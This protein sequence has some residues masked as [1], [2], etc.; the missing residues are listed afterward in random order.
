MFAKIA[1][2]EFRYQ[3][4]QPV[5]WIAA[6]ILFLFTFG[7][8]TIDQIHIGSGGN[9]HKNAPYALALTTLIMTLIYMFVTTA[10]VSNVIVRDDD[11]GFGPILRATPLSKFDY[12]NGRFV[13][14]FLVSAIGF[15][16][17]P[18]GIA[19][20]SQMPWLDPEVVGPVNLSDY[21]FAYFVLALPGV[22]LTSAI[23]FT[24][25]TVTRSMMWT[26]VGVVGFLIIYTVVSVALAQKTELR[27]LRGY[28][29]PFG[30]A[31]F[32]NATRYWTASERNTLMPAFTGAILGNRLIW[33]GVGFVALALAQA[34]FGFRS[35]G[36]K[37]RKHLK[38]LA[39]ASVEEAPPVSIGRL[40]KP[41]F[42]GVTARAQLVART[43]FEMGQVFKSPAYFVLLVLGLF[44][45]FGGLWFAREIY[46]TAVYP[47][48]RITIQT[49]QGTFTIIP[50]IIAIYYAGELVWRERDRKTHEIIDAT[51]IPNWAFVF[52][53]TLAIAL[54]LISTLAISVVGAIAVQA[55]KGYDNFEL[56]KFLLWYIAPNAI[57]MVLLAA[58]AVFMQSISPHKFVGWGLMV[59]YLISTLVLSN[60]GFDQNLYHYS[61]SPNVPLSDMNGRGQF[62]IGQ[63]WFQ[64]YWGAF[65]LFLLLLSYGLWRRGTETRLWPRLRR[66]PRAFAGPA[67]I[68]AFLSLAI[69]A[70]TGAWIYL[71]TNVWNEHRTSIDNDKRTAA[72]EKALLRFE[73]TPQPTAVSMTFALDLFPHDRKLVTHGSYVLENRTGAPLEAVHL[74]ADDDLKYLSVTLPG[75][76]LDH[77]YKAFNYRIYKFDTPLAPGARVTLSFVTERHQIGFKNGQDTTKIVDNGTFLNNADFAPMIGIDRSGFLQDRAKRRLYGLPPELRLAKLEDDSARAKNYVG[78]APWVMADITVTTDADQTPIAPGYKVS[79]TTHNGRRTAEF[80][81][82][83]PILAFFSVQ[84]AHYAEKHQLYKGIDIAVYYDKQHP[85]NVNRMI[86]AAETGLDYYQANFSPYQ[87][88]QFRFIEFPDYAQ[89]A[90]SFANT[91]PWSEGLGF[92]AD[93]RKSEDIDYVTYVGAHELG[94]QWW[95]HQEVSAEMQGGT[96]LVETLA[97]YSALMVMEKTYGPDKIRQFLKYELDNYLRSRG[98][99]VVEEVPLERVE[100]QGYIH[101]RKGAVVMYLLKDQIGEEAVNRAL[102]KL[103][104]KYAFKGAPYASSKDLVA[105]FRA[106]APADKQ[107]LITDL[108]EKITLF[109]LEAE[110]LTVKKRADGKYDVRMLVRAQKFYA[111]GKGKETA[112]PIGDDSFDVGLFTAEPG[113]KDFS[114][115]NVL[116]FQRVHLR[117]GEQVFSFVTD[118]PPTHGGID[119]YNKYIDRNS[120]DNVVEAIR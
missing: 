33:I 68:A 38:L 120:D 9:I 36:A 19:I 1:A 55:L 8:T 63:M 92:I 30:F 70:G 52:P 42:D 78:N 46:G 109:D 32:G 111:D 4:R 58:L 26:Y 16:A 2:F 107:Q 88:K 12:L 62:W 13:G 65:A 102:R 60:L 90:Q 14:A 17:V 34:T 99:E 29:E 56:G 51:A 94:H 72:A 54:V 81:T 15:L 75:A 10:F 47:V 115:K 41:R 80:K 119:P 11:T 44:N 31:A 28:F 93:V 61:G 98:G 39:M 64:I 18:L 84:S 3:M 79:D 114:S 116:L 40:P 24:L 37:L 59:I 82:D 23:F 71:N 73:H 105:L 85:Y 22:F 35:K 6:G 108:F 103:L 117:A 118:K 5:L 83:A 7:A 97:Q 89:F 45:A 86:K 25:A 69:F 66:L 95:A 104:A 106:E 76:H 50:L 20:G 74:Q 27:E 77:E 67:G 91:V 57:D 49:L 101:Y 100:N 21:L 53:K 113:K 87:F 48:T 112:T 43:R 110:K 96:M